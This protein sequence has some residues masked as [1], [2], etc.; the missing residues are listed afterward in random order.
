MSIQ[1]PRQ[2]EEAEQD[3]R[4][5][6]QPDL[7]TISDCGALIRGGGWRAAGE[8]LFIC[9]INVICLHLVCCGVLVA[10]ANQQATDISSFYC[11]L[12]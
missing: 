6:M 4:C 8:Q 2:N 5:E 10:P 12:S 1:M 11:V 3:A 7:G 9:I